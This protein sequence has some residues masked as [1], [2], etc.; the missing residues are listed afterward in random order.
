MNEKEYI[1]LNNIKRTHKEY[2][3]ISGLG[4]VGIR[5]R[6]YIED[7]PYQYINIPIQMKQEPVVTSIIEAGSIKK[8][9]ELN[10]LP[11]SEQAYFDVWLYF[12][13]TRYKYDYEFYAITC[14]T[15]IDKTSAL[16]IQFKLN[17]GQRKLLAKLMEMYYANMPILII[18]LKARQWGGSTLIQLFMN[19]IQTIHKINWSSVICAHINQAAVNIRSMFGLVVKNMIPIDGE[20]YELKPFEGQQNI[21]ILTKRGCK[22]IVGAATEPESVRSQ[23]VKM[24]HFSEI[25]L[26][27]DTEKMKTDALIASITGSIPLIPYTLIAYESTAQGVGDFFHTEWEKAKAGES[28]FEPVF[29]P[30]YL[31]D[32]YSEEFNGEFYNHKGKRVKGSVEDFIKTLNNYENNLFINHKECSLENLNWYRGKLATMSSI[33]K[34]KQE[35]PSDDIEAFQDSGMPA[36]RADEVELFRKDCKLPTAVGIL[37]S[38]CNPASARLDHSKRKQVLENI[39]FTE[40]SEAMEAIQNA[41]QKQKLF[42]TQN[43]LCIWEYPE[44]DIH[45]SN[46]YIVSYDPSK[47]KTDKADFG[48]I[49]VLDRYWR[50][51]GG[52]SEIVAQW[53]GHEDKDIAIWYACQIAK[54]YNNAL[55]VVE[56]NTYESD[57]KYE[58]AEF[59]FDTISE[60]YDNLYSR[61]SSEKLREGLPAKYGF[62]TNRQ[63][64]PMLIA[65]MIAIVR[66][67]GYA[68][69]DEEAVNEMRVYEKKKNGS[70]G[71][72]EGKHDDILMATMIA[73]YLDY[74][75]P[76]PKEVEKEKRFNKKRIVS[77]ATL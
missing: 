56:S 14:Q 54:Y 20:T 10:G 59:I 29:V 50:M 38:D 48:V 11:Y 32:I 15:I 30:W 49:R 73:L 27:P 60:Y 69:Y 55:L 58:D 33:Q 64:K 31:I 72:K 28:S 7:A 1:R 34:M 65:N 24:A 74:E 21:K 36:F 42:K 37:H 52:V 44:T 22:I 8:A 2:D 35:Y 13:E 18:L 46:R 16:P 61:T 17:R 67:K 39:I 75:L 71:A 41:D 4:C 62:H 47:G 51:Y 66:E 76:L 19:W 45:I 68:E 9:I 25:G 12:C 77:E 40:D 26:Y 53:R 57:E 5:E 70:F 23:D 6:I 3:P 43:K 63:T